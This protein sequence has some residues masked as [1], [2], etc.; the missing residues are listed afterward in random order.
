MGYFTKR[1]VTIEAFRWTGDADQMEDPIWILDATKA[2]LVFFLDGHLHIKTLEG[3][4]IANPGDWIIRGIKGELYPCKP[5]IFE[6]T[7]D[8]AVPAPEQ[9]GPLAFSAVVAGLKL[10]RRFQ[11]AGWNGKGMFIFL[12]PG[13]RFTVNREPLLSILGEGTE[14]DYHGH[15]DMRTATGQIVPWLC[16]QTD[17]L[18]DDW[19]EI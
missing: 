5:D 13:S 6:A 10:G 2:G 14:V 9:P 19:M 8:S 1:P 18:A 12:V 16:S 7:Y 11:R 4:H 3:V 17:M 15:V